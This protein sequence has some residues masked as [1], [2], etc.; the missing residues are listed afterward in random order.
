MKVEI[1]DRIRSNPEL[2]RAAAQATEYLRTL[3][4]R[5]PPPAGVRWRYD[6]TG[7]G[8][9]ELALTDHVGSPTYPAVKAIRTP[10]FADPVAWTSLVHRTW[11]ELL[12]TRSAEI[13]ARIDR[14]LAEYEEG[15]SDGE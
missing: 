13:N 8:A 1:D 15:E 2:L 3:P 14:L 5:L 7:P 4:S 12:S 11:M 6:G 10:V 9:V